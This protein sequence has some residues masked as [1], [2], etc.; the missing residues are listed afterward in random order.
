MS[1]GIT[2]SLVPNDTPLPSSGGPHHRYALNIVRIETFTYRYPLEAPVVTSFGVMNDRP[3]VLVRIEDRDGA[4]GWG[5]VWCNFPSCGA[6][7]RARLVETEF[8]PRLLGRRFEDP[9]TATRTLESEL[10]VLAIQTGEWGPLAQCVAGI[11]IALWDLAARREG[12]PLADILKGSSA[13]RKV[14]AYASGIN[15]DNAEEVIPTMRSLGYSA[16]KVK[17]GL[18]TKHDIEVLK[19]IADHLGSGEVL[20]ADANQAWDLPAALDFIKRANSLSLGWLE[21]PLAADRPLEEWAELASAS[22][23]PL[24]AGE[25]FRGQDMFSLASE[26]SHFS[27]L[28]PDICKWGGFTGCLPVAQKILASGR[29]YCPHFLGAGIGLTASAHLLAAVGGDGALEIDV[30]TNPLRELL[31]TPLPEIATDGTFQI[32]EKPGLHVTPHLKAAS[33]WLVASSSTTS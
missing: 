32:H 33:Q 3:A 11:D 12:V 10:R 20:M 28:Q 8:A 6:E 19:A 4:F 24:A 18:E 9:A 1:N 14:P 17:I 2:R 31:A 27:V 13:S 15:R 21:E 29:R 16:F 22:S 7:H 25:N 26:S 23:I 5:E 30:N